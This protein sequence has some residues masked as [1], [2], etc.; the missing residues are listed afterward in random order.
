MLQGTTG[1]TPRLRGLHR[2][3][4]A[5]SKL[6]TLAIG[7]RPCQ[8]DTRLQVHLAI[9]MTEV[10][11]DSMPREVEH[12][13]SLHVGPSFCHREGH[14]HF[15]VCQAGPAAHRSAAGAAFGTLITTP[16]RPDDATDIPGGTGLLVSISSL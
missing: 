5:Q 11:V 3:V 16:E 9:D 6:S 15:G 7:N 13:R 8:L 2:R 1:S 4:D 12:F 10:E 14:P